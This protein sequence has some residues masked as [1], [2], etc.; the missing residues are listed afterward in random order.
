[1][2][3]HQHGDQNSQ[4]LS[5]AFPLGMYLI[6]LFAIAI[7]LAFG[8]PHGEFGPGHRPQEAFGEPRSAPVEAA[9]NAR[10]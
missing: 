8:A 2:K 1:M 10:S 6:W 4:S 3:R 5:L 7:Y 9:L